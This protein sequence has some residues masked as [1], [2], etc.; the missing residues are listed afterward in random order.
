[1]Q[2]YVEIIALYLDS[3]LL[4]FIFSDSFETA[5]SN[6]FSNIGIFGNSWTMWAESENLIIN[7]TLPFY[8]AAR[9]LHYDQ[10]V[11][12]MKVID[13]L[14]KRQSRLIKAAYLLH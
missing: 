1:M 4:I 5:F 14:K 13:N 8:I 7:F 9:Q 3:N 6:L 2:I 11:H 10:C 12:F